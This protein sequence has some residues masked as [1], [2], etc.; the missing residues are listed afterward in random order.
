MDVRA[1]GT[2]SVGVVDSASSSTLAFRALDASV[3]GLVAP[4]LPFRALRLSTRLDVADEEAE[5]ARVCRRPELLGCDVCDS[6]R[7]RSGSM[8][9]SFSS[10]ELMAGIGSCVREC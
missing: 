8:P 1:G 6:S 3:W 2:G 10:R 7:S 4:R 5:D 9:S